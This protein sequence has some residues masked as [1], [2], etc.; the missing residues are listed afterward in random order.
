MY[1]QLAPPS[2]LC[3]CALK[4]MVTGVSGL[5]ALHVVEDIGL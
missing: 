4:S 2:K 1:T 5:L 3:S